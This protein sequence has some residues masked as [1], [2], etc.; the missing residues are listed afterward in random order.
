M[1]ISYRIK[2]LS[3]SCL[4]VLCLLSGTAAGGQNIYFAGDPWPP[5]FTSSDGWY[6]DGGVGYEVTKE[7]FSRIEGLTPVFPYVPWKRALMEV[8]HGNRDGIAFLLKSPQR[9]K[10]MLFSDPIAT[11]SAHFFYTTNRFPKGFSWQS[12]DDLR[13]KR[14]GIVSGY[15]YG[16]FLDE[17]INSHKLKFI[18]VNTSALGFSMLARGRLDLMPASAPVGLTIIE[19]QG[20]KARAGWTDKSFNSDVYYIALSKKSPLRHFLKDINRAILE[21]I[22]DG[23]I[24]GILKPVGAAAYQRKS[25]RT[26]KR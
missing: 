26:R 25:V 11:A 8:K 9:Q 18:E 6:L 5:F 23:S 1:E 4:L 2:Q 20:W 16:Q 19:R 15:A 17:L 10:I 3:F 7:I 21:A 22:E 13:A 14:I 12:E 24:N